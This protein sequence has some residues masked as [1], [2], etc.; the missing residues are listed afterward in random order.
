[1]Q[2]RFGSNLKA[3][4]LAYSESQRN[5][6]QNTVFIADAIWTHVFDNGNVLALHCDKEVNP[7]QFNLLSLY[8]STPEAIVKTRSC[9]SP[10]TPPEAQHHKYIHTINTQL[11]L[12]KRGMVE[13]Q[14][15]AQRVHDMYTMVP[16]KIIQDV[17]RLSKNSLTPSMSPEIRRIVNDCFPPPEVIVKPVYHW[18]AVN[19]KSVHRS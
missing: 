7:K 2:F 12:A 11:I 15:M 6:N 13:D 9:K 18:K 3:L 4:T 16:R 5:L 17:I 1:M 14:V 10:M 8:F 19:R